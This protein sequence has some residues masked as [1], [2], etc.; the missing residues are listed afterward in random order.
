[1]KK[2]T[3]QTENRVDHMITRGQRVWKIVNEWNIE[4]F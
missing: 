2:T 3:E 4:I 1:M